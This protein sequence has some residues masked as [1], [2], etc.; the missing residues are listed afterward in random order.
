MR[1]TCKIW[2]YLLLSIMSITMLIGCTGCAGLSLKEMKSQG[3][4]L[5]KDGSK[6]NDK[7]IS[8]AQEVN[9]SIVNSNGTVGEGWISELQKIAVADSK[10]RIQ[11]AFQDD[12]S[13]KTNMD[14]IQDF[15]GKLELDR[16][17]LVDQFPE[18]ISYDS[19]FFF[20]EQITDKNKYKN[21]ANVHLMDDDN[22]VLVTVA[23][24][25]IDLS[26]EF[27]PKDDSFSSVY[28]VPESVTQY[29]K[30]ISNEK[31]ENKICESKLE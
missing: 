17:V 5:L 21:I 15:M 22:I 9:A 4:Q 16:W 26:D 20:Q 27:I 2:K 24:G 7:L 11:F 31:I 19:V 6:M 12:L 18:K 30:L 1:P 14:D 10:Y 29:L 13:T 28:R 25:V 3:E 23:R 8:D